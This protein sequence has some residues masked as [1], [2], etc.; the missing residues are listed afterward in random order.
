M[1]A[2]DA[3][4]GIRRVGCNSAILTGAFEACYGGLGMSCTDA[5]VVSVYVPFKYDLG[6]NIPDTD[7]LRATLH[8]LHGEPQVDAAVLRSWN[9]SYLAGLATV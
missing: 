2:G 9:L 4:A 7:R 3:L 6:G 5:S 8:R 1:P